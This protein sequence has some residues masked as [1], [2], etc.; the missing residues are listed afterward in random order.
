ME[1][2]TQLTQKQAEKLALIQN[3]TKQSLEQILDSALDSYYQQVMQSNNH[4]EKFTKIGFV[5]CIEAEP[6][7]AED[8]EAILSQELGNLE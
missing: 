6:N 7:L 1:M 3:Q 2:T 8:S 4:L 5:G